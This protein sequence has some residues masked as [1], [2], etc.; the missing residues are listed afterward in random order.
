[1][2]KPIKRMRGNMG[3]YKPIRRNAAQ[4]TE[5]HRE[6]QAE[7]LQKYAAYAV[8]STMQHIAHHTER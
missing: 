2:Y 1:V 5:Q 6:L 8:N 3:V 7:R 4:H